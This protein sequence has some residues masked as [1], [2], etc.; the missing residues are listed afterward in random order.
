MMMMM[1]MMKMDFDDEDGF[2]FKTLDEFPIVENF[3]ISNIQL[4]NLHRKLCNLKTLK[5]CPIVKNCVIS[6]I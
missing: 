4:C 5:E 1:M 6:N 3:V 2:Y